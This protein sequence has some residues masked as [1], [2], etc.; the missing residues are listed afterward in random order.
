MAENYDVVY[1]WPGDG[2]LCIRDYRSKSRLYY[3]LKGH[4]TLRSYL[5]QHAFE[6]GE[7]LAFLLFIL[8]DM[9]RVNASKPI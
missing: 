8:E 6:K 9:V 2:L 7:F 4:L 3:D 1:G 5:Q